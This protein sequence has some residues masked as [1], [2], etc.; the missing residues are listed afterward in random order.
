MLFYIPIYLLNYFFG[1]QMEPFEALGQL[2][3]L[4]NVC[5]GLPMGCE[6]DLYRVYSRRGSLLAL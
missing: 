6:C 2:H 3:V 4:C 1:L 5:V